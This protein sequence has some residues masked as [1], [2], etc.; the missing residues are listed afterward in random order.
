[1]RA[2]GETVWVTL[3]DVNGDG[4]PDRVMM[5]PSGSSAYDC[6]KV[7]RLIQGLASPTNIYDFGSYASQGCRMIIG[8]G[9]PQQPE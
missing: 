1:M 3:M 7:Q 4:L 5:K 2:N 9:D 8:G 6:F